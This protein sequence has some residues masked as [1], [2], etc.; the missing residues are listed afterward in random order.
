MRKLLVIIA[1]FF[2]WV[3]NAQN[4]SN[5]GMEFW[6]GYGHNELFRTGQGNTQE[7][8]LYLSAEQ[9]AQVT[10]SVNGTSW[11]RTYNI[12]ANTVIQSDPI[13][14]SGTDDARLVQEGISSRGVNIKSNVP[15][16]AY[17][18]QYGNTS[19]GAT[20]LLPVE[21]YGNTYY[22]LTMNQGWGGNT[23][24]Y[25]WFFVIASQDNTVVEI[26]P[27]QPTRGGRAAGIPFT[28]TLNKGQIY[29]VMSLST[30]GD[31]IGSKIRSI[32]NGVGDCNPI[33]VFSGSSRTRI[34]GT[35]G[36]ILMQQ[37]FPANAWGTRY[38]TQPSVNASNLTQSNTNIYRIAVRDPATI[39]KRNGIIIPTATLI[40]NFYYE[41]TSNQP[42]YFEAD[43]PI[44][45]AQ[46]FPSSNAPG[47]L[48][49]S[50][51][52]PE[53]IYLSPLEQG[54]KAT[55]FY[56]TDKE[57]PTLA[58]NT[59]VSI[60]IPSGGVNS[61]RIDGSN[62]FDR[63]VL[64]SNN[65]GYRIIIKRLSAPGQHTIISDS[66]FTAITYGFANAESYG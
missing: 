17:A 44:L 27:S 39:V 4:L 54:I 51:G 42:E 8:V 47:Y 40:G 62:M 16:V 29:N 19:S 33:T 5:K 7:M 20:L 26:T 34:I 58:N 43:G 64:H 32:I 3:A 2:G 6:V 12:P 25:G 60:I 56:N 53:M 49:G 65:S 24:I 46:F 41:V 38:L 15:I 10:V 9:A 63:N 45:V 36:D 18:H 21:T 59:F 22:S 48:G 31:L 37:I 66:S 23:E 28:V 52:D 1:L 11:T 57:N 50:N 14:K 13:P 55:A 61:L 35:N 30:T